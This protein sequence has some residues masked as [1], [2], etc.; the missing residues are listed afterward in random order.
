MS[1]RRHKVDAIGRSYEDHVAF[2][3]GR[4]ASLVRVPREEDYGVDFYCQP[5]VSTGP[6]TQTVAELGSL[7]VKGG[8][9]KLA[10]G[11]LNER[12]EWRDYEITWL[13]SLVTPLYRA[14]VDAGFTAVELFSLWPLWWIFW[15][16][17]FPFEVVFSTKAAGTN[18]TGWLEPESSPVRDGGD[19]GDGKRWTVCLGPPFLRLTTEL[20]NDPTF[21]ERTVGIMRAW[22][23]QDRLVLMFHQLSIPV[24]TGI[25][26][27]TTNSTEGTELTTSQFW[28]GEP[29]A[30]IERL[31]Q[32]ASPL[33]V[34]LGIHLQW[35]N[36]VSAYNLVPVL[37]WLNE[38]G[39]LD[40]IGKGLLDGLRRT[41]ARGVGPRESSS[42]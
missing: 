11:G 4:V 17:G 1:G 14:P 5:L 27:W 13:R 16:T 6:Q 15:K 19:H 3:V 39:W 41:Q 36:D 23:A 20:L 28:R 9:A 31:C 40:G 8:N 21:C 7:Q 42:G 26:R 34:N 22:I 25:S 18:S 12:G 33:L 10:Y 24:L 2:L 38:K 29:G 35:Q 30:N 37:E 32:T